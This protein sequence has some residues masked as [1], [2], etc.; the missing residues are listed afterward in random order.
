MKKYNVITAMLILCLSLWIKQPILNAQTTDKSMDSCMTST[1]T[2]DK[3]TVEAGR[4]IKFT[5]EYESIEPACS[6]EEM[7]TQQFVIDFSS[8]VGEYGSVNISYETDIF[9]ITVTDDG[10][11]TI[12]F[13]SWDSI[14]N[15]L[16]SFSG[17]IVFTI[18][19]SSEVSGN[20]TVENDV[21]SDISITVNPPSTDTH[22]TSKWADETYASVGDTLN[23][24]IR[25]NTDKNTVQHFIGTDTPASGL[26]YIADSAYVK[27][28][29]TGDIVDPASYTV[30]TVGGQLVFENEVPFDGTYIINYQM[31][32]TADNDNYVNSFQAIYDTIVEE[33]SWTINFDVGGSGNVELT[34]GYIDILKTDQDGTPLSGAKFNIINDQGEVVDTVTSGADGH[35]VSD[36]LA[37]GDYQVIETEAPENFKLDSTPRN[38]EVAENDLN[39]TTSITVVNQ[40]IQTPDIELPEVIQTGNLEIIKTNEDG[41]SLANAE[42][43]ILDENQTVVDSVTTDSNGSAQTI[44]LPL[45]QYWVVETKAP[46]G[47]MLDSTKHKAVIKERSEVV[48]VVVVDKLETPEIGGGLDIED[49]TSEEL[50]E[51]TIDNIPSIDE[52]INNKHDDKEANKESDHGLGNTGSTTVRILVG[53]SV[54][55]LIV[56]IVK[57]KLSH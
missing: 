29:E 11:A 10:I 30:S 54:I 9:N 25:I 15:T 3:N 6:A 41:D 21:N 20:I 42:F 38:V 52:Q 7:A 44:D 32:V 47:Y 53:L 56:V 4:E 33:G 27:N 1:L 2:A 23:Y 24:K 17:E 43:D 26:E 51:E 39:N 31:L 34:N 35:A 5:L 12:K 28:L 49:K 36:A 46:D 50:I 22:N 57:Y 55:L 40:S 45:G 8:L 14:H 48:Q 13:Q 16:E 37:F 18:Q 19:V